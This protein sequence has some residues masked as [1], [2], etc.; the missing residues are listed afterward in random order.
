MCRVSKDGASE[1]SHSV[2]SDSFSD[3]VCW[4]SVARLQLSNPSAK[5]V[6]GQRLAS[7]FVNVS[8]NSFFCNYLVTLLKKANVAFNFSI[9]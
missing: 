3:F 8:L 7:H 5:G 6:L 2:S 9:T 1:E 4:L